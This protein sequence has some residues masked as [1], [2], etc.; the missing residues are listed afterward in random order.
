MP[1]LSKQQ[2][3]ILCIMV[4][5]VI[6]G[7]YSFTGSPKKGVTDDP[8]K[9]AKELKTFMSDITTNIGQDSPTT[10]DVYIMSM[11]EA[12]WQKDP[13]YERKSYREWA[14]ATKASGSATSKTTF[15]YAGYIDAGKKKVAI[16]NGIEYGA[17]D[18]L[19]IEGY[20]LRN[21]TP[22]K[23]VIENKADRTKF[24]VPFQE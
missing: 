14:M 17:G 12:G 19:E 2:T 20:I 5:A 11:A 24:D 1:K 3:I 23:V 10:A 18:P 15:S 13:F 4:I 22:S 9:K 8:G 6:F 16:I 21:I 7:V